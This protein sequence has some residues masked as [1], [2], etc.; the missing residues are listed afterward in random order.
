LKPTFFKS[1]A[2][3]R[4]WLKRHHSTMSE[5]LVGF[6]KT[7]SAKGGITYQ[8]ALDE[9][10]CYGWIDGVRRNFDADSYTIRFTPRKR[11]SHW[12]RINIKRAAELQAAGLMHAAGVRAY[13]RRDESKTINYSYEMRAATL[14]P[15]FPKALQSR[16]GGVGLLHLTGPIV[17]TAREV[18]GDDG[19]AGRDTRATPGTVDSGLGREPSACC[20][21]AGKEALAS[22]PYS[23]RRARIGST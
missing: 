13:E 16:H 11:T 18:L 21:H 20:G 1:G 6:Y 9:A 7:S 12:S 17:S 2:Q 15:R 10:L 19:E 4:S 5:L 3:F 22:E 14:A 23:Y 8:Q